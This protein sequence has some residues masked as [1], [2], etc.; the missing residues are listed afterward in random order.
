[1]NIPDISEKSKTVA[2]RA[3]NRLF[4]PVFLIFVVIGGWG[5]FK[6]HQLEGAKVPIIIDSSEVEQESVINPVTISLEESSTSTDSVK[7]FQTGKYVG[8]RG[9]TSYYLPSCSGAKRISEKNKIWFQ[10]KEEAERLGYKP[11]KSC[12]GI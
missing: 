1:M 9:G 6:I 7:A 8:S 5:L 10:T 12:K 3:F 4:I 2:I 11:S